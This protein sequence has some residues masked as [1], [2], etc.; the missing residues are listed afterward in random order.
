MITP[1]IQ[2]YPGGTLCGASAPMSLQAFHP[3]R[4]WSL[5]MPK[6]HTINNRLNEDL[7]SLRAFTGIPVFGPTAN[8][9]F[10]Y[11]AGVEVES[12]VTDFET[13]H[14]PSG[15]YAVF[16]YQGSSSDSAVWRF[17]YGEWIPN[18][19]WELDNRPHFERLGKGYSNDSDDSQEQ[20]WIPIRPG[21]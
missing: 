10:T 12:P 8:P 6:L 19:S 15:T 1:T 18:S 11:W 3:P 16:E 14:I 17:I 9:E 20:I 4:V 21:V 13:L 7:I 2:Q 5:F